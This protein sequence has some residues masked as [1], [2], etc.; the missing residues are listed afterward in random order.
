MRCKYLVGVA[1]GQPD[2]RSFKYGTRFQRQNSLEAI[3]SRGFLS[4]V[5]TTRIRAGVRA[6]LVSAA[7]TAG[8]V[9]GFGIRHHDLAGPFVSLGTEVMQGFGV[10][11]APALV[12]SAAG[13]AAHVAWMIVWGITFAALAHE[14]R[15][16]AA[17]ALAAITGAAAALAAR[18]L[19]PAAFGAVNFAALSGAQLALCVV[20]M[21]L[22][23]VTGRA[24][25]RAE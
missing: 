12:P 15:P 6:G 9:T 8:A 13:V 20:L 3:P 23:L 21:T 22:G 1:S 25:A 2:F 16:G 24:L 14:R 10:S 5:P 18:S 4:R 17:V 7:A 11:E 19:V